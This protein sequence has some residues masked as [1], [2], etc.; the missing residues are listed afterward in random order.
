MNL[1]RI[2]PLKKMCLIVVTSMLL[3]TLSAC[4]ALSERDPLERQNFL[5]LMDERGF[6]IV[7][8]TNELTGD[9]E[10]LVSLYLIAISPSGSYQIE[11]LELHSVGGAEILFAGTRENAESLRGN[12]SSHSSVD[13]RNHSTYQL[14]SAGL[15]SHLLRVDDVFVFVLGADSDD[16]DE[17]RELFN[18]IS[19]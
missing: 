17:I 10:E 7:D 3:A 5:D 16:R 15:Y 1:R 18:L 11:F 12:T 2:N 9:L 4:G 19:N 14:T 13:G 8:Y 6:T